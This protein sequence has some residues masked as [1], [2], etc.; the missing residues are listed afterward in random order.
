VIVWPARGAASAQRVARN[1][2]KYV[3]TKAVTNAHAG[4]DFTA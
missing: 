2:E 4:D 1:A 3:N